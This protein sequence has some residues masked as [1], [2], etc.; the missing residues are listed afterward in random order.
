LLNPVVRSLAEAGAEI[1]QIDEPAASTNESESKLFTEAI[2]A[3]FEGLQ[4]GIEKAVHLCYSNYPALFPALADCVADSYLIE[5]TNHASPTHFRPEDVDKDTFQAL[6]LFKD[7]GMKSKIGV[8]VIDIHSDLIETPQVVRDRLLYAANVL[9]DPALVQ[10]NPDCGLR[11]RRWSVAFPKLC[12]MVEG[13]MLARS[14][15]ERV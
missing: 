5:F 15:F 2:N 1:I 12:N 4:K 3:S 9:G 10:V 14:E 11:T 7:Y 6:K 13:A 8:G